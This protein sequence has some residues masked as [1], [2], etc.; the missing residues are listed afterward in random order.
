MKKSKLA[1]AIWPW[2]LK[3]ESQ[4]IQG[5]EDIKAVG[6]RYFE[7][8]AT[9]V[10]LFKGRAREFKALCDDR[11]VH[12]VSFYFW[13]K[14]NPE[15]DARTV[16]EALDFLAENGIGSI[17]IQAS[18]K[19][20]GATPD[21]LKAELKSLERI[22]KV[23]KPY[24]IKPCL[25]PH[26]NT[27]VMYEHEVDFMMKHTDPDEVF[28]GPDT[29]HLAVGRCD[30]VAIFDRYAD[31][32][33]FVHLKD[34]KKNKAAVGDGG[35]AQ[36]F[37]VYS[38]FLELGEGEV[39]LPAIFKILERVDYAGTLTVEL[40]SSRVGNKESAAMNMAY[41]KAHGF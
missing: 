31:R 32:I 1:Y 2:G 13:N 27:K 11:Q 38:S 33:R 5:M 7:S 8:V 36:G 19:Q 35:A 16:Q 9:A 37:E 6:F 28:F 30:P 4:M 39:D 10:D 12:A 26:A 25:H 3:N 18:G 17:T 23:C 15:A 41:L 20:G 21:E 40:D 24:G 14:G 22:G 34:V 29:A